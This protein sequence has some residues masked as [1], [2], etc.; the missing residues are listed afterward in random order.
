MAAAWGRASGWRSGIKLAAPERPVVLF[1]GDGS[2]LYN[3]IV[4]AFGAAKQYDLPILI[5]VLNNQSYE[6]M[7]RGHRL[8]YPDGVANSTD[9]G[10]GVKI[11]APPFEDLGRPFGCLAHARQAS[12]LIPDRICGR[13]RGA[14][15]RAVGGDRR[16]G[17][18]ARPFAGHCAEPL[19]F[20]VKWTVIEPATIAQ[21][22]GSLVPIR[23]GEALS[24]R[25]SF[26]FTGERAQLTA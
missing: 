22:R 24:R 12:R 1:A 7:G 6:L 19:L 23:L 26:A 11:D 3:P 20:D 4:Q 18:S 5:V 9:F 14:G 8:Y 13:D 10:Y 17:V 16:H 15:G 25:L 21:A 2:M